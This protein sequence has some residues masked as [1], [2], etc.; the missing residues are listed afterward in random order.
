MNLT[1]HVR[2]IASR[3]AGRGL[4]TLATA[5]AL[6]AGAPNRGLAQ[7]APV[8][9]GKEVVTLPTF[10]ITETPANPYASKQALSSS[11]VAMS[12]QDIPQT[13]SVV[14]SEFLQDSLSARMIDAAKYVTPV[15]ESTLPI[16]GD[17]YMIRGFQV[18]HEFVDGTEISGQDGYSSSIA[19]YNLERIEIIK[20]PNAILVPG[21][22]PGGQFNPITK[23]PLGKDQQSVT[24]ELAQYYG[25]AISA[26]VNRVLSAKDNSMAARMVLA[27]WDSKGYAKNQFRKG[28]LFAP[29]FS[30]QLSPA[31]KLTVKGEFMQS[32]E[33]IISGLPI[34]PS[35]GSNDYAR[36]ATG[37]PRDWSFGDHSDFRHRATERLTFE[38]LSN[39]GDHVTSRLQLM[40]NHVTREDTGGMGAAIAGFSTTRNPFTGLYEPGVA[41]ALN[42]T[43][44][45]AV[46]TSTT[47]GLPAASSYVFSRTT[48]AVDLFYNEAHFR[49]DYAIK[50]EE[51]AFKST[52]IAG[53]AANTSK[54]QF[55]TYATASRPSV[56]VTALDTITYPAW[57]YPEPTATN[58]GGNRTG[59]Q[60]DLQAF[61]YEN[62]SL[63][64]DRL[65]LSG[66]VS[67]FFGHLARTDTTGIPPAI[68]FPSYDLSTTAKSYG[69][70][71]K[72]IK[73]VSVFY[74]YNSSGGTMP[75][76]LNPGTYGPT[77]RAASGDQKE[78]GVKVSLL[79]DKLTASFAHFDIAQ[80]NYAVP[81]SDYYTQIALGNVAA[82]NAL[83]NPL[84]LDLNSKGW[85]FEGNY[86]ISKNLFILGNYTSFKIR[87]P[88]TNVR[89]RAVPD[90]SGAVYADYR[91]TEGALKNFG[92]NIGVDFKSDV[93]G[94]NATGYTT[95][96]PLAG[97]T[98][99]VPNQPTFKV[100]GRTL[101][102]VGFTYREK[103][104]TA[105]I[106]V[107]NATDKDYI[108]AAG[109]RTAAVPG[110]PRSIKGSFTYK[111]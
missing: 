43:G 32:R 39:L 105:R 52:T 12:I 94:E 68:T 66:G 97:S 8:E 27:F 61:I 65:L 54:V 63:L 74:S 7:A 5:A 86:E 29:S 59:R 50:F 79:K 102:N 101:V 110:D 60:E 91:F 51:T 15:V 13:I 14:T 3:P 44:S 37:L 19:P 31:H 48:N 10:T 28:Y 88:I 57:N 87:Q 9:T 2:M 20:G 84:Y 58:G 89:V 35:V 96:V 62:A 16:G 73:T 33:S 11:R 34:D 92:V 106:Q 53:V 108:L 100:A 49:N 6:L 56:A 103:N 70:V 107:N 85:E 90:H 41:Y 64:Q 4:F 18:S 26:D 55:K 21:G 30:W 72:P 46:V 82:A 81:N 22:S 111:F 69:V 1:T 24:L 25:T 109:S 75:S 80:Q 71:V 78:F 42:Q 76:S 38:L 17:R 36:I 45:T 104:W 93:V 99:F 77:F 23:S 67:R 98:P 40:A 95:T 47:P 83:P